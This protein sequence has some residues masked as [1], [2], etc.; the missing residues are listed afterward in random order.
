MTGA[1]LLGWEWFKL[2][3][4]RIIWLLVAIM[5]GFSAFMVLLRFGE[6]QFKKDAE[7]KDEV[8]FVAGG[9]Q[10]EDDISFGCAA[11]I[12]GDRPELP[13][14]VT[15]GDIDV[16]LTSR[17][18]ELELA[19]TEERLVFLTEEF[20]LPGAIPRALRWTSI[21][22]IPLLA[23]LTVLVVGSEYTWGTLRTTLSRGTGRR[24]LLAVKLALVAL[25]AAALWVAVTVVIALT[26]LLATA[27]ASGVGHGEWTG[28]AAGDIAGDVARAWYSTLPYVALAALLSVL[29]SAWS[30]GTL[31]AAGISIG[32]FFFDLFSMARL[33]Q[34]FDGASGFGWV[35][36]VA[37]VDLGWNTAAWLFGE[38]GEP[39]RGFNLVGAIG[40]ATYPGGI[41]SFAVQLAYLAAFAGAAFWLFQRRDIAGPTG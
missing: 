1:K 16:A 38:G 10:P 2:R 13:P 23:F 7:V 26:S 35:A 39:I 29:F 12:A 25:C 30:G 33:L 3:R 5:V 31:A 32:Y 9:P 4:R 22:S 40:Q 27:L 6:Y 15:L 21:V 11:F 34:L 8:V 36:D 24:R 41:W 18:C 28:A 17:E 37:D 20:T 19:E 14:E